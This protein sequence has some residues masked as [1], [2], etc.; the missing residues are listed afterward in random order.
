MTLTVMLIMTLSIVLSLN[1]WFGTSTMELS[2][3][4]CQME[5]F[6]PWNHGGITGTGNWSHSYNDKW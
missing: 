3:I 2:D 4:N 1:T 6:I 5:P